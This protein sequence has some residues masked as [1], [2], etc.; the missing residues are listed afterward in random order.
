MSSKEAYKQVTLTA[1][2]GV[3]MCVHG[4]EKKK[5]LQLSNPL[6]ESL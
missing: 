6:L 3:A 4:Q 2:L 5:Q 1:S